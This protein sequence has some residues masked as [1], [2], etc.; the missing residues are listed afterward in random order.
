LNFFI[1]GGMLLGVY[2]SRPYVTRP[3]MK[4]VASISFEEPD[5]STNV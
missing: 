4:C 1:S 5:V 2:L 3:L